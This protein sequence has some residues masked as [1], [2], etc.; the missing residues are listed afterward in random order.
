MERDS[1]TIPLIS[2]TPPIPSHSSPSPL[3]NNYVRCTLFF[4][5][6]AA[7]FSFAAYLQLN[8]LI[9]PYRLPDPLASLNLTSLVKGAVIALFNTWHAAAV[10]FA[11]TIVND[12]FSREWMVRRQARVDS[13]RKSQD[14]DIDSVSI[15]TSGGIDRLFYLKSSHAFASATFK[16]AC[17]AST[18]LAFLLHAGSSA[19]IVD[20]G[21]ETRLINTGGLVFGT[22]QLSRDIMTMEHVMGVDLGYRTQQNWIIPK[23]ANNALQDG[24]SIEYNSDIIHFNHTCQWQAPEF[25][26]VSPVGGKVMIGGQAFDFRLFKS[27]PN[28]TMLDTATSGTAF[29]PVRPYLKATNATSAFLLFG[30]NSTFPL[31]TDPLKGNTSAPL[32]VL[33]VQAL[34]NTI[35]LSGLPTVYN[36][37]WFDFSAGRFRT[38]DGHSFL[39]F[40]APLATALLCDARPMLTTGSVKLTSNNLT[41]QS[42]G[43]APRI[44]NL[45]ASDVPRYFSLSLDGISSPDS[46]AYITVPDPLG[47]GTD[48]LLVDV[49]PL[50]TFLLLTQVTSTDWVNTSSPPL[51][52]DLIGRNM[53]TL[54]L[55]S[56]KAQ[57]VDGTGYSG[58]DIPPSSGPTNLEASGPVPRQVLTSNPIWFAVAAL[59]ALLSFC[60]CLYITRRIDDH[61][62]AHPPFDLANVNPSLL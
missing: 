52:L 46:N 50:A 48:P 29:Y 12:A 10:A 44:G 41:I 19:I 31:D 59:N 13:V 33:G 40:R 51:S 20:N 8:A 22:S 7:F 21:T 26:N 6:E 47:I 32:N 28:A 23:P 14:S 62:K 34:G 45:N 49:T 5:I 37:S 4:L 56:S 38:S 61:D 57:R 53:D 60:L 58:I 3:L 15:I 16:L 9:L 42:F 35:D 25:M 39:T 55:S 54:V 1:S 11:S 27:P 17:V 30:G 36:S 43:G 18:S 24:S 2:R